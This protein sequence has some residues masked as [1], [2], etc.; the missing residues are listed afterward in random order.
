[1]LSY[2]KF[3]KTVERSII[4]APANDVISDVF[5]PFINIIGEILAILGTA[6]NAEF[7]PM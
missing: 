2:K 1:M 7:T 3:N 5:N 4:I 6:L